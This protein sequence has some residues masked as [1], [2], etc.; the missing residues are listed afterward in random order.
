MKYFFYMNI[1]MCTNNGYSSVKHVVLESF[2]S[3][4]H[5]AWISFPP[6]PFSLLPPVVKNER[7]PPLFTGKLLIK[8]Q[9]ILRNT[10]SYHTT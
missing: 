9:N 8:F 3:Q 4:V 5:G 7:D 1:V 2:S 10:T 6:P